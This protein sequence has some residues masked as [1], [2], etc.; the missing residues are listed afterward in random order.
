MAS[1]VKYSA[2]IW[3]VL[4]WSIIAHPNKVFSY[5]L[6]ERREAVLSHSNNF[7]RRAFINLIE[8]A[9]IADGSALDKFDG[10]ECSDC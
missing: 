9:Q 4:N 1:T 8:I 10:S 3:A 5:G 6:R 7:Q 2:E